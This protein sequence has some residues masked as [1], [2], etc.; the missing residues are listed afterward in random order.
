MD[1]YVFAV[2]ERAAHEACLRA[3]PHTWHLNEVRAERVALRRFQ[4]LMSVRALL[5]TLR[6]H[7]AEA[8]VPASAGG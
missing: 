3:A 5:G 8:R 4:R 1:P 7:A 2:L 6:R